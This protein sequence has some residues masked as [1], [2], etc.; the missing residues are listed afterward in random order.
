MLPP[1]GTSFL[2]S[3]GRYL[4][5][6]FVTERGAHSPQ[7]LYTVSLEITP[8]NYQ[9]L[10]Q[11]GHGLYFDWGPDAS[12]YFAHV[13]TPPQ[14]ELPAFLREMFADAKK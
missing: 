12:R 11:P 2:F 10:S 5:E 3:S 8:E 6:V 14:T 7:P 4:L 9:A 1:D 13:R